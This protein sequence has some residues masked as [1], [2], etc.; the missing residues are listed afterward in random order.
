MPRPSKPIRGVVRQRASGRWQCVITLP[1]DPAQGKYPQISRS[2]DTEREAEIWKLEQTDPRRRPTV[3]RGMTV[4]ALLERWL[5]HQEDRIAATTHAT[6]TGYVTNRIVPNIGD[7]T[8]DRLSVDDVDDLYAL[9]RRQNLQPASIRQVHAILRSALTWGRKR[10]YVDMNVAIDADPPSP[11]KQRITPPTPGQVK[12]LLQAAS[13]HDEWFGVAVR[14]A[15]ATGA[16]RG[17]IATLRQSDFRF[18]DGTVLVDRSGAVVAGRRIVK[19]LK[20]EDTG[21]TVPVDQAT[22]SVAA[23]WIASLH[24][25]ARACG[26]ELAD[27]FYLFA[28][29][30]ACTIFVNPD[31]LTKRWETVRAKV[32]GC[33]RVRFHDLRHFVPTELLAAGFDSAVITDRLKWASKAMLDVYGHAVDERATAA[34][35]HIGRILD[36]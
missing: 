3:E 34:G 19:G 11:T 14:L 27:D 16:R 24:E 29:D 17:T 5:A 21:G 6:Y 2:F 4:A 33:G 15:A 22:M 26:F 31:S 1:Y 7:F 30:V 8:L 13:A 23:D 9:L 35:D 10:R 28:E 20:Y 12:Q 32:P 25:R 36:A 18:A